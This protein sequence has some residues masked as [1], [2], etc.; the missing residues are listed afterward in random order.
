[1]KVLV[2]VYVP[3]I[4]ENF[5]VLMPDFL[6]IQEIIMLLVNNVEYLS[7]TRYI[8]TGQEQLC[9]RETNTVFCTS[10]NLSAY[11]LK[12]GEHLVLI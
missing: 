10:Q 9:H 8:A 4:G 5:D 2:N 6:T 3:A 1:M 7:N 11:N 12:N